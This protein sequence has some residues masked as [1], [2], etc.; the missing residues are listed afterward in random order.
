MHQE[1]KESFIERH[2]AGVVVFPLYVILFF[3]DFFSRTY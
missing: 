3:L 1:K 2:L